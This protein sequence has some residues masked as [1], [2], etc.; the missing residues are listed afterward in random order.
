MIT[1]KFIQ[2]LYQEFSSKY[3]LQGIKLNKRKFDTVEEIVDYMLELPE[4]IEATKGKNAVRKILVIRN[5]IKPKQ[6]FLGS[7]ITFMQF[8]AEHAGQN[9]K[10]MI[11]WTK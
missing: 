6:G 5:N 7:V 11:K 10:Q 9:S 4:Y 8:L 3:Q 2:D 1:N